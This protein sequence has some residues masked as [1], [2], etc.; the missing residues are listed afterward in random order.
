VPEL[1]DTVA[2]AVNPLLA[3]VALVVI[4]VEWRRSWKGGVAYLAAASLGLAGIYHI[5]RVSH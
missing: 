2:D 4:G 1:L 5:Y 3:V